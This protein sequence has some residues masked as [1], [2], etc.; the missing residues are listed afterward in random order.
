ME[1]EDEGELAQLVAAAEAAE[2]QAGDIK[3]RK[4][5]AADAER[6]RLSRA[7]SALDCAAPAGVGY[8]RVTACLCRCG[9]EKGAIVLLACCAT[10]C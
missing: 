10:L 9:A 2:T 7:A 6:K 8:N 5:L 3:K 1:S 4:A